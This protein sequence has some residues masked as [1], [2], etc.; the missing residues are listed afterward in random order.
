MRTIAT[1]ISLLVSGVVAF[2]AMVSANASVPAGG[3]D[4]P[5][6]TAGTS[7]STG[8]A[9]WIY[10]AIA[11]AAVAVTLLVQRGLHML[12]ESRRHSIV[13]VD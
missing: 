9:V 10:F 7:S 1:T 5:L 4:G 6:D 3:I 11:A 13:T 8:T 2:F 12:A